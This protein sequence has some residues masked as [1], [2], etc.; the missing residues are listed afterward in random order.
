MQ[1]LGEEVDH[2]LYMFSDEGLVINNFTSRTTEVAEFIRRCAAFKTSMS[3]LFLEAVLTSLS[4]LFL[5]VYRNDQKLHR[6][7]PRALTFSPSRSSTDDARLTARK[8]AN[9]P[10][11]VRDQ[12]PPKTGRRYI[13]VGGVK[14]PLVFVL[15]GTIN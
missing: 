5:Y 12:L 15:K 1:E 7:P 10:G 14:M 4:L 6:I 3:L 13:V 9:S 2:D 8:H 11:S